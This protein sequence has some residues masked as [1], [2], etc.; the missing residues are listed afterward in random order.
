MD[1]FVLKLILTPA[2]I[3]SV[4]LAGRRWGPS[5][6]GW[7]IGLPFTSGPITLF[8]ALSHGL[9]FA[10]AG[11]VG[12]LAGAATQAVFC[13]VYMWL[14]S[15][16]GWRWPGALAGSLVAFLAA[17]A[18]M[19]GLALSVMPVLILSV[20]ALILALRWWSEMAQPERSTNVVP[21]WDLPARMA[22]ATL[23]VLVLTGA[24][25]LLGARLTGLL[26]PV[27]VYGCVLAGFAHH[28]NGLPGA[29]SVLRGLLIGLFAF[30]GF[31]VAIAI[32][33][34]P[35]GLLWAFVM[36]IVAALVIQGASGWFM[37]RQRRQAM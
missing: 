7:L 27:P 16:K 13:V 25:P 3:G 22:T 23:F 29:S 20:L 2:L 1:M 5:V 12:T 32:L 24:A 30:V 10:A 15:I 11:A 17:T 37:H 4:S 9:T 14:A 34:E 36:A 26:A 28:Q 33:I 21:A 35:A 19:Q 31:Y 8:V 18:A 6:S